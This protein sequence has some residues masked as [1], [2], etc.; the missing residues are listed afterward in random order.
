MKTIRWSEEKNRLLM[1][2]RGV[3]FEDVLQAIREK[4]LLAIEAH[5]KSEKYP[6]H[7]ILVILLN[8]YV[9]IVPYVE[10]EEEIFLKTVYPDRKY[11]KKYAGGPAGE[12][13][14]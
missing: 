3:S 5:P 2:R 4:K 9:H 12:E 7:K 14:K 6:T 1:E 8:G 11:H 10:T 13:T